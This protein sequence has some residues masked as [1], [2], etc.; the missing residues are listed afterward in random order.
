[1]DCGG[2]LVIRSCLNQLQSIL[3]VLEPPCLTL[4]ML[5]RKK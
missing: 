4:L 3:T 1:M 5:V 2:S